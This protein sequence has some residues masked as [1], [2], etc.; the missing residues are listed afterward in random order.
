MKAFFSIISVQTN[1]YSNESLAVG[2]I[3]VAD[4]LYFGYSNTKLSWLKK[5]N[6]GDQFHFLSE[7][8]LKKIQHW[9]SVENK[10]I[11]QKLLNQLFSENY[12][13]YLSQYSAGAIKFSEPVQLNIPF[14]ETVF[15]TYYEKMIGEKIVAKK[16]SSSTT[17][18]SKIHQLFDE[19]EVKS[20]ADVN[21]QLQPTHFEGVL[22]ETK[23]SLI[24]KNG[25]ID[26][27]QAIDFSLSVN[28]IVSHLYE[29]QIISD[30]LHSFGDKVNKPVDKL[31][32][33]FEEPNSD[34]EQKKLFDKVYKD[35]KDLFTFCDY[36][37][38]ETYVDKIS[39]ST[40][41]SKFSELLV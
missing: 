8:A 21:F 2:L 3:V 25:T 7:K 30:S 29:A 11:Q 41:Y 15:E 28:T 6:S 36:S 12:F 23:L 35:K 5:L 17:F 24:T 19:K 16:T 27:L 40:E 13:N 1:S 10:T 32:L 31:K 20:K 4:K 14:N 34:T 33:A 37:E 22:K 39:N 9:V 26:A 18:Q 38:V